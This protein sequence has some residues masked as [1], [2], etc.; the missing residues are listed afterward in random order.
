MLARSSKQVVRRVPSLVSTSRDR[1]P[2]V[3]GRH[4]RVRVPT[5]AA[6]LAALLVAP[7]A[8]AQSNY[9]LA[10]VGG[11]S[12]LL[13]GTGAVY[14]RDAAAGFLNPAT[15][16]LTDDNRLSFSVNFYQI[17]FVYAPRWY[18]PGPIDP[19][20]GDLKLDDRVMTD[21]E[22]NAMPSSLCIFFKVGDVPFLAGKASPSLRERE[23]RLGFCL[24]SVQNQ[25]FNYAAEG[26]EAQGG[27]GTTRQAQ[28]LSQSYNRFSAGPTYAMNITDKLAVGASVHGSLASHRSLLTSAATT[29]GATPQPINSTFYSGSR[30]DSFQL[31]AV[32]GAT[33]NFG[34]Q[35]VALAIESPSLHVYGVGGANRQSHFQGIGDETSVLS[36]QGSFVSQSPLRVTLGTGFEASWGTAEIDVSYYSRIGEAYSASLDGRNVQIRDGVVRDEEI[37][38]EL[39]ERARGVM[40]LGAGA[41]IF[42]SP[43]VSMLTGVS[44][45]LSAVPDGNLRGDLFNYFPSRTHR[46]TGSFGVASHGEGGE[47]L[48]GAEFSVGWGD[49]L[50]VNSYQ[51][52]PSVGTTG[53][54]TYQLLFVIAGSTS[55]RAIKRAYDDVK[56]VLTD[57][58][59]ANSPEEKREAEEA[60]KPHDDEDRPRRR[61]QFNPRDEEKKRPASA[62]RSTPLPP[63]AP[64]PL[65]D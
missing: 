2:R 23:A 39:N 31:D 54:G 59:K 9:R 55:L 1:K 53:H 7:G 10:P 12:I 28:S 44:T 45:D 17:S 8:S 16:V 21:L 58:K 18:G 6:L 38:L 25:S 30:G 11:R 15:A 62:P 48:G 60:K 26:Y 61:K 50:A 27:L 56:K 4:G 13:G 42:V 32:V 3:G 20:Y 14:G 34:K 5:V 29:Y 57:P 19:R 51:L 37:S 40:N 49:R 33:Y 35:R 47:L 52:P 36:A 22:F 63:S 41:E 64:I 24:A 65:P 43:K 46:L